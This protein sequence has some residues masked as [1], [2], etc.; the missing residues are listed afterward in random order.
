MSVSEVEKLATATDENWDYDTHDQVYNL[1][2][3]AKEIDAGEGWMY[4]W[5]NGKA[6]F[7]VNLS[8]K[9][10]IVQ[11]VWVMPGNA[12]YVTSIYY[13]ISGHGLRIGP[14]DLYP[15]RE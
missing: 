3:G 2:W 14:N 13:R 6:L 10:G 7:H 11:S 4:Y 8:I 9:D 15:K 12:E 1:G 5:V